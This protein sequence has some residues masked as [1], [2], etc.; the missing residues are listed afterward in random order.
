MG[1]AKGNLADSPGVA[2]NSP[3]EKPVINDRFSVFSFVRSNARQRC[4]WA[5]V[6]SDLRADRQRWSPRAYDPAEKP[7]ASEMRPYRS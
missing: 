6:G 5:A 3:P 7:V 4:N 2:S 1:P